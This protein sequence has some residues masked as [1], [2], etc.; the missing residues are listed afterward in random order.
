MITISKAGTATVMADTHML[1]LLSWLSPAFPIGGFAWSS[2]LE[3]ACKSEAIF[4]AAS[5]ETWITTGLQHGFMRQ[6]VILLGVTWDC[7]KE[8]ADGLAEVNETA[9][10]LA[11][12]LERYEE[13]TSLGA[14]F[15]RSAAPWRDNKT[16][17]LP[18][19]LAYPVAV[20]TIARENGIPKDQAVT[21]YLHAVVSA[22]IQAALRLFPLGQAKAMSL[23]KSLEGAIVATA[24]FA[25]GATLDDLGSAAIMMDIAGMKHE[26]LQ[27]R[28]FRS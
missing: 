23:Q 20:G 27:S 26:T 7:A 25:E 6:D 14:A 5:L 2:G 1:K 16:A 3:T 13:T 11:G 8:S 28:I 17:S 21:A 12:S 9:L 18:D 24:A 15:A 10:A 22:Q 19:P 4:D